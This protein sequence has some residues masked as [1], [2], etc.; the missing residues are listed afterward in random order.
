MDFKP[1]VLN[2]DDFGIIEA[3]DGRNNRWTSARQFHNE[4]LVW[5]EERGREGGCLTLFE[6]DEP[7]NF[8]KLLLSSKLGAA[9]AKSTVVVDG[10]LTSTRTDEVVKTMAFWISRYGVCATDGRTCTIFSDVCSSR[11]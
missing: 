8:G 5:Q 7:K 10:V 1:L 6:G 11:I 9:N 4:L 2:G 3:G